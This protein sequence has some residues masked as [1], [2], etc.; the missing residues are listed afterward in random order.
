MGASVP[1]KNMPKKLFVRTAKPERE[2]VTID[3]LQQFSTEELDYL[4]YVEGITEKDIKEQGI[5][6]VK[7][8]ENLHNPLNSDEEDD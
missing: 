3:P 4:K 5:Q 1:T 6:S 8:L 7:G 2:K